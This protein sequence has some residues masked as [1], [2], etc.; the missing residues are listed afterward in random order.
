MLP[1]LVLQAFGDGSRGPATPASCTQ[2]RPDG[3]EHRPGVVLVWQDGLGER[4]PDLPTAVRSAVGPVARGP[5]RRARRTTRTRRAATVGRSARTRSR[6]R[7]TFVSTISRP[8]PAAVH[9]LGQEFLE[10]VDGPD[11]VVGRRG[12]LQLGSE[13]PELLGDLPADV[14][15]E[16]GTD[17]LEPRLDAGQEPAGVP[18][19]AVQLRSPRR[20]SRRRCARPRPGWRARGSRRRR[21]RCWSG[22][23]PARLPPRPRP[24]PA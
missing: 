16:I 23:P 22:T 18:V 19:L 7:S 6:A 17:R 4:G 20:R 13:S 8:R 11:D 3:V 21:A 10:R 24:P 5:P 2:R 9:R 14:V 1:L 12:G 15:I